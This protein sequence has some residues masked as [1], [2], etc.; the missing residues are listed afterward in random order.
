MIQ[1]FAKALEAKSSNLEYFKTLVIF[2]IIAREYSVH[3]KNN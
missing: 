2:N 3:F 1:Q